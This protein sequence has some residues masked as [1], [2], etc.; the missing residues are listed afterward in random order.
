MPKPIKYSSSDL[1]DTLGRYRTVSLFLENY[2]TD[3]TPAKYPPL[4]SL[5]DTDVVRDSVL[6]PSLKKIYFSYSHIPGFEYEFA[7][8]VFFSWD[9]WIKLTEESTLRHRFKEWRDELE[10]KLKAQAIRSLIEVSKVADPKGV[11]A[12]KYLAEKG[13]ISR[14][15]R[16][17]KEEKERLLKQ[18]AAVR[19]NL[20][21]DMQRLGLSIVQGTK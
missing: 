14:K 17:S 10:I 5:R 19:D 1:V 16:P 2:R 4:F 8:D 15:G 11:A 3:A 9:H 6:Y 7:V 20:E 13:Y 12:A 18:E 21:E